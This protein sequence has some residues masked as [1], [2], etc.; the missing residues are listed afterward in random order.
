MEPSSAEDISASAPPLLLTRR[1]GGGVNRR[2]INKK[3]EREKSGQMR[4]AGIENVK[5]NIQQPK[6]VVPV[7]SHF[8][9]ALFYRVR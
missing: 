4:G 5:Y 2:D 1:R 6:E 3:G 9:C 8:S 7:V